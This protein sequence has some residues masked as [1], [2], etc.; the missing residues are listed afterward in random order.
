[1]LCCNYCSFLND[2]G[3]F[4][5]Q[6]KRFYCTETCIRSQDL[7]YVSSSI[8]VFFINGPVTDN[9]HGCPS[10]ESYPFGLSAC[11]QVQTSPWN[12]V[13]TAL[14]PPVTSA[15]PGRGSVEPWPSGSSLSTLASASALQEREQAPQVIEGR[16]RPCSDCESRRLQVQLRVSR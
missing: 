14:G 6:S 16:G 4:S 3:T 2:Y 5:Y 15:A 12:E 9:C 7:M 8:H 11:I 10:P 1:M 13:Q